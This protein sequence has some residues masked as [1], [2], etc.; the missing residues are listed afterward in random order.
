M[1][2][3]AL[4]SALAV[5]CLKLVADAAERGSWLAAA[6]WQ[7]AA[8]LAALLTLDAEMRALQRLEATSVAPVILAAQVLVPVGA[9]ALLLGEDWGVTPLGGAV[10]G[11]AVLVVAGGAG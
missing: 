10:L 5:L 6:A 3:A 1:L 2:S 7:S 4:A 9:A 8:G 11:A